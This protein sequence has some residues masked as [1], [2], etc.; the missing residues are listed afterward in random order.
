MSELQKRVLVSVVGIPVILVVLWFGGP[1]LVIL[2]GL[3]AFFAS[4]EL[5]AMLENIDLGIHWFWAVV[6]LALFS[7]AVFFPGMI[8]PLFWVFFLVVILRALLLWDPRR[9]LSQ[10]AFQLFG[11]FYLALLPAMCAL[12]GLEKPRLLFGLILL[13]WLTDTVAYFVGS[14]WGR[15]RGIFAV[16]PNKSLEGFAAGALAPFLMVIILYFTGVSGLD[17]A[18]LLLMAFAAGIV[19]Q[20]GDLAESM[21]KR[22]CSVKDSSHLIPGHGGVLDRADSVLLAG[23]FLYS[24]MILFG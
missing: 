2:F 11:A 10:V 13:I 4:A 15:R 22:F 21:L 3:T 20:L 9:S 16:S 6:N 12:L 18:H 19:G 14:K 1:W 5:N 17:L 8:V 23:S 24:V 7:L